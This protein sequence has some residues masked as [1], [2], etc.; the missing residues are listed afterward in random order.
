MSLAAAPETPAPVYAVGLRRLSDGWVPVA[1][2]N[3]GASV[4]GS[5][6]QVTAIEAVGLG[7]PAAD[8]AAAL[9]APGAGPP[10][11][12]AQ[13]AAIAGGASGPL[14]AWVTYFD[15]STPFTRS[16]T[17]APDGKYEPIRAVLRVR[18]LDGAP[19]AGETVVSYR[20]DSRGGDAPSA[21]R[22]SG[23]RRRRPG[24]SEGGVRGR[25]AEPKS[26]RG[27][28]RQGRGWESWA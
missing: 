16:K 18:A 14:L 21:E 11:S 2:S 10:N 4:S 27:A 20:A 24:A 12:G 7:E 1:R 9:A 15:P 8:L 3:E 17:P 26:A 25:W 22:E 19:G 13:P 28:L 6:P 23:G 5:G